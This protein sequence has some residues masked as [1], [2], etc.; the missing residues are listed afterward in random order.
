MLITD[1]QTIPDGLQDAVRSLAKTV[2]EEQPANILEFSVDH[3]KER[4]RAKVIAETQLQRKREI[5]SNRRLTPEELEA[6]LMKLFV[7]ADSDGNGWLSPKEFKNLLRNSEM[8]F[9]N[10]EIR[11]VLAEADVDGDGRIDYNEF[12][13]VA[14]DVVQAVYAKN[15]LEEELKHLKEEQK[16]EAL[17]LL[18]HG[19]PREQLELALFSAFRDSDT[20]QSGYLDR[21]EF[22]SALREADIGLT[23]KEIVNLM[24]EVDEDKNGLISYSEFIPF[25][26]N[27]IAEMMRDKMLEG[28]GT[29]NEIESNLLAMMLNEDVEG[30]GRLPAVTVR[31]ILYNADLGLNSIHVAVL[32][33]DAEVDKGGNVVYAP[34]CTV[35]SLLIQRFFDPENQKQRRDFLERLNTICGLDEKEFTEAILNKFKA[36][37]SNGSGVVSMGTLEMIL[38]DGDFDFSPKQIQAV[39]GEANTSSGMVEYG[40]LVARIF[41]LV[42]EAKIAEQMAE[43]AT[44]DMPAV[45]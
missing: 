2:L 26:L 25:C 8:N 42:K 30:S 39:L 7:D 37:D 15:E 29:E 18:L 45:E 41:E 1:I 40:F 27:L 3:F 19:M 21:R 11:W 17:E 43:A 20:D 6:Y 36:C 38:D 28:Q 34:F 23:K 24:A 16:N 35:A 33:S 9:S 5:Q 4:V 44:E 31:E 12:I 22:L 32:M 14:V 10:K 13:P